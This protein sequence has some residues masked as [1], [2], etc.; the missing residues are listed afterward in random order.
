MVPNNFTFEAETPPGYQ[1]C[2]NFSINDEI[3]EGTEKFIV[4]GSS[5]KPAIITHNGCTVV[6]IHDNDGERQVYNVVSH[7]L[8]I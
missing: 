3:V 6:Y 7:Y 8:E 4:C 5:E 1:M 2:L